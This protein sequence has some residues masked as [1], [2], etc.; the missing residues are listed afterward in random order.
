MTDRRKEGKP[1]TVSERTKQAGEIRDRWSWVEPG[2]W[3]ERMLTALEEGVK[4]GK[5][6]SLIDKVYSEK[7]LRLAFTKVKA[8][9]GAAGADHQ[10]IQMFEKDLGGNL[11]RL[12]K[13]LEKGAYRPQP[14]RRVW[15]SKPGKR[16][17][18]PL[19]IP[20][21]RDRVVQTAVRMVM[22]PI[23]ERDFGEQSYGFRPERGCKDALCRVDYLLKH[24]YT[25]VVDADIKSYFDTISHDKLIGLISAKIS[26]GRMI[27]LI[28]Q[29]L[30][31]EVME[32]AARWTPEEGTP[33]GAVI[34]PLLSNIYLDSLDHYMA[35]KKIEMVRYA[36]DFII[37]CRS[38]K[39]AE[40]ALKQV[41]RWLSEAE[42]ELHPEKTRIVDA[43]QAGGFDFLGYHFERGTRWPSRKSAN[44]FRET[45]RSKTKRTNGHSMERIIWDV[46]R[47]TKGWFEYFKHSHRRTFPYFDGWVRM[48]L[49]SILRKRQRRTGVGR[50]PDHLRWPNAYFSELGLFSMVTA[51]AEVCQS[52][53][54]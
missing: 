26:D 48:R 37:L 30:N 9:E 8:K 10:T 25:W 38:E 31:Q 29:Y 22:E 4:G 20:T 19:G 36:D 14:V 27:T 39:E 40:K 42:L 3:T 45:I 44:R 47:S 16:E 34:S 43:T 1:A 53:R 13:A 17:K 28:E 24:G 15:I 7:V 51:H 50:G 32:T 11:M 35:E 12:T 18:R 2:V 5:W 33:Q 46:N 6:F 52:S 21:V 41:T 23:F 54:R 49:R